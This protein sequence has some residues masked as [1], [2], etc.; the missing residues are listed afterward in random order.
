M[1]FFRIKLSSG[2][3]IVTS[4]FM[5]ILTGSLLLH[6]P[7]SQ[8]PTSSATYWDNLFT[9]VSMVCVTGLFTVPVSETYSTFGQIICMLLIQIGGLSLIGFIG[10]FAL[11]GGRKLSF[12]NMATLQEALTRSDTKHFRSFIKSAFGFTLAVE[13]LGALLLSFQFVPEFGWEKGLFS[14]AFVAVSAFCNAGFD[15]FGATSLVNYVENPLVNLTIAALIIMGGLGFSVWFDFQTQIG[16]R[17]SLRKLRFHT[18]VVLS[19]T[20]II[21]ASGTL[22]TLLTEWN[23]PSTIGHLPLGSKVLASF[24][25]TVTMRTAGF[26]SID[27]TKAEPVTLLLYIFQMM[28]GGAPG[29]TAGGIK[30]TAFLTLVLYARSEI[31][32]LPHTNFKDHTIDALTIRKAFATFSVFI[33]VFLAGLVAT[34]ITD[35][36]QPLLFLMFEV[37][38]ALATVGVTAN[39][40]PYLTQ[41]SQLILMALMFFGRIGPMSILI[42][43]S[44][45]KPSKKESLHYA[46][47]SMIV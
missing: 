39:L 7:F 19:L 25:Q 4:F 10:L 18:K 43:L 12:I 38:S 31:M 47:S 42:S 17:R 44:T 32:G 46:K 6:L 36:R 23:N 45:R 14:A 20:A 34:T 33:M 8:L 21:L 24:F 1:S 13:A 3:R 16:Q 29:G 28:L 30:I 11:R 37:M 5:V 2:Q 22:L 35:P 41:A 26:A 40:T 15:N 27:Y 9:A